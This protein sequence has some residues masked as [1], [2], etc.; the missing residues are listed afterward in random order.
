[1]HQRLDLYGAWIDVIQ[2]KIG[3]TMPDD[4]AAKIQDELEQLIDP[5]MLHYDVSKIGEPHVTG[6]IVEIETGERNRI[7][8]LEPGQEHP[9]YWFSIGDRA[10]MYDAEGLSIAIADLQKGQHVKLWST[11]TVEESFPA[12]ASL[13]RLELDEE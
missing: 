13:R 12:L 9:S 6:E 8:I 3:V 11:G 5:G 4:N 2:N 10:K 1:M 7:L